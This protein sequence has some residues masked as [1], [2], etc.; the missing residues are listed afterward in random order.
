MTESKEKDINSQKQPFCLLVILGASAS[1][2]GNLFG[3]ILTLG[4]LYI[5]TS[6]QVV[7]GYAW[8]TA[9]LCWTLVPLVCVVYGVLASWWGRKILRRRSIRLRRA[10]TLWGLILG[11]VLWLVL[12][13]LSTLMMTYLAQTQPHII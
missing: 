8:L 4:L 6:D 12:G 5:F 7:E 9:F 2:A 13:L 1:L 11:T 3:W 10:I